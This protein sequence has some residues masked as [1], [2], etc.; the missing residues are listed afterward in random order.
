MSHYRRIKDNKRKDLKFL[1]SV[2]IVTIIDETDYE[3]GMSSNGGH[4]SFT[5]TYQFNGKYWYARYDSSA[6][7]SICPL[8]GE[9]AFDCHEEWVEELDDYESYC[10]ERRLNTR[11]LDQ[12]LR[13][14]LKDKTECNYYPGVKA[15]TFKIGKE[16]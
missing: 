3:A 14:I 2:G 5:T 7:F 15:I 9:F 4:Y 12:E 6:D 11:A 16:I 13:S 10:W 1:E 8:C